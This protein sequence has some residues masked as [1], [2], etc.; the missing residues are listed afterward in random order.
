MSCSLRA[1][2][3][4]NEKTYGQRI[5]RSIRTELIARLPALTR[6]LLHQHH[7]RT[8]AVVKVDNRLIG[9]G[10]VGPMTKRLSDL[11][12]KRTASEGA[13]RQTVAAENSGSARNASPA[14]ISRVGE[15]VS[16]SRT[17]GV[18]AQQARLVIP[19]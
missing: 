17:F 9:D 2:G 4:P 1:G 5:A 12:A 11:Y 3:V 8:R 13:T 10:H 7:G 18:S 19:N 14:R 6:W 16:L 15:T